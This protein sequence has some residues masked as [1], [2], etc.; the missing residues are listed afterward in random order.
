MLIIPILTVIPPVFL[1]PAPLYYLSW[2]YGNAATNNAYTKYGFFAEA[3]YGFHNATRG[4]TYID[5]EEVTTNQVHVAGFM[6]S[7]GITFPL[8]NH[9][10]GLR[11]SYLFNNNRYN[12]DI[13]GIA[14]FSIDYHIGVKIRRTP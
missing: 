14:G 9:S 6:V 8:A 2:H 5:D 3:G 10:F 13:N 1:W 11:G 12:P 4:A 7:A